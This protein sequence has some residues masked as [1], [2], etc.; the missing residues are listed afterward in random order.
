[1]PDRTD[2]ELI[3]LDAE[4]RFDLG[5]LDVSSPKLF[6]A[7]ILK[8]GGTRTEFSGYWQQ[9]VSRETFGSRRGADGGDLQASLLFL[10]VPRRMI[11]LFRGRT[12]ICASTCNHWKNRQIAGREGGRGRKS[13][14]FRLIDRREAHSNPSALKLA[15]P[16]R[17]ITMWSCTAM[18]NALAASTTSRVISMS[19]RLG[20]GSPLG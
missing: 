8:T 4:S 9:D 5:E 11:S 15:V 1:M 16:P 17:P 12:E 6:I 2:V 19:A 18:R 20:V 14:V 3:L 7:P 10:P 13:P